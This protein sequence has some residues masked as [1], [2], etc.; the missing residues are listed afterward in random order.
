MNLFTFRGL[1]MKQSTIILISHSLNVYTI[2]MC[3]LSYL[4]LPLTHIPPSASPSYQCTTLSTTL[5]CGCHGNPH[6]TPTFSWSPTD[7]VQLEKWRRV[8]E[9]PKKFTSFLR[10][11]TINSQLTN[12]VHL[13]AKQLTSRCFARGCRSLVEWLYIIWWEKT[14]NSI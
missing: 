9:G 14:G 1:E 13:V 11:A 10:N 6:P 8:R 4:P 7:S 2:Q 5:M 12:N 3:T